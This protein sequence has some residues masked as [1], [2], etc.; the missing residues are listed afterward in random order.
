MKLIDNLLKYSTKKDLDRVLHKMDHYRLN[1]ENDAQVDIY[2]QFIDVLEEVI[3]MKE[4]Q[5]QEDVEKLTEQLRYLLGDEYNVAKF[6]I[7]MK[8]GRSLEEWAEHYI[9]LEKAKG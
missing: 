2:S 8:R 5:E 7:L 1:A 6:I 3:S 4:K 9:K